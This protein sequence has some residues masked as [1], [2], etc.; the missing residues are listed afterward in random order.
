MA[1]AVA[2]GV[3]VAVAGRRSDRRH[4]DLADHRIMIGGGPEVSRWKENQAMFWDRKNL[5]LLDRKEEL[6]SRTV[7]EVLL[8]PKLYNL[9]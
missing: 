8:N 9:V 3:A 5:L 2:F 7:L 4:A 1:V 6:V